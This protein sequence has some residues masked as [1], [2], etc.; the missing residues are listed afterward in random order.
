MRFAFTDDHKLF[1]DSLRVFSRHAGIF[2]LLSA[3]VAVPVHVV[4]EGIGLEMLTGRYDSTPTIAEAAV[5]TV[6]GFLVVMPIITGLF[7]PLVVTFVVI[8]TANHWWFD[9]VLGA[10]VAGIS[11]LT[12]H[13]LLA[14]ARP[15]AWAFRRTAEAPA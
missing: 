8:A 7:Y 9:A 12:A 14:R 6:V 4:V 1:R 5:P 3:A 15:E 13:W 2:I 10:M 11:A